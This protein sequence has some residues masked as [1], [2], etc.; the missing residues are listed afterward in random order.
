MKRVFF[1]L[2]AV[3]L[4]LPGSGCTSRSAAKDKEEA[5]MPTAVP[6]GLKIDSFYKKYV[7]A[8]G[9]PVVSSENV[10]DEALVRARKVINQLL[11]KRKDIKKHMVSRGCK[12]MIIG[13]DEQVCDLPE[14]AHICDTPENIAYWNWRARGFGGA[15]EHDVSASCGEENVLGLEQDK[16]YTESILVHEFAHI[17]HMVDRK[18]VV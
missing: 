4:L 16:Y 9:I 18:S 13:K 12:V 17:F 1:L 5:A 3:V 10:S 11:S 15:P 14:Y 7:N 6:A 8:D 2:L